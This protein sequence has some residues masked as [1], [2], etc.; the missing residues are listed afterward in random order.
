MNQNLR[1]GLREKQAD[2]GYI[3]KMIETY[4]CYVFDVW[5]LTGK[6]HSDAQV[7]YRL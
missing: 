2:S 7:S 1:A 5:K 3:F 6:N 4:L